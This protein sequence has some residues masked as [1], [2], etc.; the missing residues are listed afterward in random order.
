MQPISGKG[1]A[2]CSVTCKY[3]IIPI[4]F[5]VLPG[6]CQPVL[7]GLKASQL[8][9]ITI[10]KN[11]T[12]FNPVKMLKGLSEVSGEFRICLILEKY[13][14]NF[15]GLGKTKD[16][17]VKHYTNDTVKPITVPPRPISYHLKARVDDVVESIIKE[18]VIKEHPSNKPAS[19]VSCA[20]IV[21]KSDSS[22]CITMDASNLD[23]TLV[24]SNYPIPREE[25]IRA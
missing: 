12:L 24:S 10:D 25:D 5:F 11:G 8:K 6:L 18:S 2:L 22:L 14:E 17:R 19:W 7:D 21:P 3:H 23:K 16:Y 13:T 9:I 15:H 1:T 20:V 4:N